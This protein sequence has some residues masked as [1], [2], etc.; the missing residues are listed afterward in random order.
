MSRKAMSNVW[1]ESLQIRNSGAGY[2]VGGLVKEGF[3]RGGREEQAAEFC[4]GGRCEKR[5]QMFGRNRN[6]S[7]TA[8]WAMWWE[9]WR[10]KVS[11]GGGRGSGCGGWQGREARKAMSNVWEESLQIRNSGAGYVVGGLVEEGFF[12]GRERGAGCRI[13]RGWEVRKAMSNVWEE[14]LQIRNS[15]AGYGRR[16][17]F[18]WKGIVTIPNSGGRLEAAAQAGD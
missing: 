8:G 13:L 12:R 5:C 9:V 10:R 1:E 17:A 7:E 11:L 6:K 3:F 18:Y 15:G 16:R 14:S 4:E 2:G